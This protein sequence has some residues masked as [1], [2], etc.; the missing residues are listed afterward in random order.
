[1][2]STFAIVV[3]F[4]LFLHLFSFLL[5]KAELKELGGQQK[6]AEQE[7]LKAEKASTAEEAKAAK[8]AAR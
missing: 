4:R 5:Q 3:N 2:L 6:K 1:M 7:A 8:A